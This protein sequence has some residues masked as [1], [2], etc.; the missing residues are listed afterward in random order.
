MVRGLHS[1]FT[2]LDFVVMVG[3]MLVFVVAGA[4]AFEGSDA[5]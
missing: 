5:V 3:F 2:P 4:Y 1:F